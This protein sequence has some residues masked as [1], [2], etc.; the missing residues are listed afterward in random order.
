MH[1]RTL[2]RLMPFVYVVLLI[3]SALF[4]PVAVAPIA[5]FGALTITVYFSFL[6]HK[7]PALEDPSG[8][9]QLDRD[10]SPDE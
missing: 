10:R 6:R 7:L 8:D 2:N 3:G 4:F 5:I 1:R 9:R